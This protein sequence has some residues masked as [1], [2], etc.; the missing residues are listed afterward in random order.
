M[1]HW[2]VK[3]EVVYIYQTNNDL[4]TLL[5]CFEEHVMEI[6]ELMI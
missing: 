1:K 6:S 2:W 5:V 4:K 3:Y